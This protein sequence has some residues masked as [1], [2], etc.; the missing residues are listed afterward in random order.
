MHNRYDL[1][2][3][4]RTCAVHCDEEMNKLVVVVVVIINPE[5]SNEMF[6]SMQV[7]ESELL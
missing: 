2:N 1:M 7:I 3:P 6:Y 5:G 4:S